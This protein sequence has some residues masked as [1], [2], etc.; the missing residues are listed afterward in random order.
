MSGWQSIDYIKIQMVNTSANP[1]Q[2]TLA[3]CSMLTGGRSDANA[4]SSSPKRLCP[5]PSHARVE[6]FSQ[7]RFPLFSHDPPPHP[8]SSTHDI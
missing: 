7:T 3:L 6:S 8:P 5:A 4:A 2:L 1:A